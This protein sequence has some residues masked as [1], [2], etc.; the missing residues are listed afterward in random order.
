[1]PEMNCKD[2]AKI[3]LSSYPDIL[4]LFI[5]GCTASIIALHGVLDE[6]VHFIHKPFSMKDLGRTLRET[7]ET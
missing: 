6:G 1:M 4:R 7:L 5:T 2:L 3:L